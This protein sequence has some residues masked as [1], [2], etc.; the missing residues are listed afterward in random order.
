MK[1]CPFCAEEIQDEAIKCRYCRS[2][3]SAAPGEKTEDKKAGEKESQPEEKKLAPSV[4]PSGEP[5]TREVIYA[6]CPSWRAYLKPYFLVVLLGLGGPP[7]GYWICQQMSVGQTTVVIATGAPLGVAALAFL[8]VHWV[9]RSNIVRLTTTN[10]ETEAGILSKR[11]DVIELWRCRD[12]RYRQSLLDRI[13]RIA[14]I[15]IYT[16]DVT[17]PNLNVVGLPASRRIFERIRDSVE[18]QRQARNVLGVVE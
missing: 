14:H 16:T 15:E 8:I 1:K 6:G 12:V 18:I 7:L 4:K 9:R 13:L 3:L 11:I 5:Q 2:F 10:I 17:T